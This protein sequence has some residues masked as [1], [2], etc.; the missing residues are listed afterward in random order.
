MGEV[1]DGQQIEEQRR[2][3]LVLGLHSLPR[4]RYKSCLNLGIGGC[5]ERSILLC[6]VWGDDLQSVVDHRVEGLD[7]Q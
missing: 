6:Q 3:L 1:Q 2:G 7:V 4:S 5:K